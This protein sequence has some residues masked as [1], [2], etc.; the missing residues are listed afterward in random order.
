MKSVSGAVATGSQ[1]TDGRVCQA[2]NPVAIAP[3]TDLITPANHGSIG[4]RQCLNSITLKNHVARAGT[5]GN[6]R[7]N[8]LLPR[9][10]DLD[11]RNPFMREAGFKHLG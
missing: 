1:F 6:D 5:G 3:G 9:H 8:I 2:Y 10:H 7:K 4:N 11:N